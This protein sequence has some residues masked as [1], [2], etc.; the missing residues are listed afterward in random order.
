MTWAKD[1]NSSARRTHR[2]EE[3][4]GIIA[5]W[6]NWIKTVYSTRILGKYAEQG[7]EE[8]I[9]AVA[10]KVRFQI[11]EV[12]RDMLF[13][14]N[15]EVRE[16]NEFRLNFKE[17]QLYRASLPWYR[18]FLLQYK[19]PNRRAKNYKSM[20]YFYL[21]SPFITITIEIPLIHYLDYLE[22]IPFSVLGD[23][24]SHNNTLIFLVFL[25]LVLGTIGMLAAW[26]RMLVR[27]Y[28][29]SIACEKDQKLYALDRAEERIRGLNH[30]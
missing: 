29:S 16:L 30:T 24:L 28:R 20:F 12:G 25:M 2:I 22:L 18:R 3:L 19:A 13:I 5:F 15:D 8:L 17:F 6:G 21:L 1:L 9:S 14:Y 23:H 4:N 11:A 10:H 7:T 27:L 26:I